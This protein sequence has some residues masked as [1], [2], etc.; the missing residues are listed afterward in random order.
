VLRAVARGIEWPAAGAPESSADHEPAGAL[1]APDA[2]ATDDVDAPE[3]ASTTLDRVTTILHRSPLAGL[4]AVPDRPAAVVTD[5]ARLIRPELPASHDVPVPP[6]WRPTLTAWAGG[7]QRR[8]VPRPRPRWDPATWTLVGVL[9]AAWEAT[10]TTFLGRERPALFRVAGTR[11]M[12]ARHGWSPR[13]T[14]ACGRT[15][16]RIWRHWF[17]QTEQARLDRLRTWP[18]SRRVAATLGDSILAYRIV[19][20]AVRTGRETPDL[21]ALPVTLRGLLW[22]LARISVTDLRPPVVPDRPPGLRVGVARA[23]LVTPLGVAAAR[24]G[25]DPRALWAAANETAARL[26]WP[27]TAPWPWTPRPVVRGPRRARQE[28][29]RWAAATRI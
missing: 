8:W 24:S 10:G 12:A 22:S 16:H 9:E 28:A 25:A 26:L 18:V 29:R 13:R 23:L 14:L 21:D 7:H 17:E 5:T 4:I 27:L 11:R 6:F 1:I 19:R 15:A 2:N 20:A 3:G